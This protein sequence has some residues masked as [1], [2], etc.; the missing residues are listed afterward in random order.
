[1]KGGED[2]RLTSKGRLLKSYPTEDIID[3]IYNCAPNDLL[4]EYKNIARKIVS[5]GGKVNEEILDKNLNQKQYRA[6]LSERS[7]FKYAPENNYNLDRKLFRLGFYNKHIKD[8][9]D[10]I[11]NVLLKLL[12]DSNHI[13]DWGLTEVTYG[14]R[15]KKVNNPCS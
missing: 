2:A 3:A 4:E 13:L 8:K 12:K 14:G 11:N 1:M 9:K 6:N 5:K 15:P 10:V 7:K